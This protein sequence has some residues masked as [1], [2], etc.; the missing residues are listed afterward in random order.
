MQ[1]RGVVRHNIGI[2]PVQMMLR[3]HQVNGFLNTFCCIALMLML[4]ADFIADAAAVIGLPQ[5]ILEADGPYD[6]IRPV[7]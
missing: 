1:R 4:L 7:L 5:N 3:E 6:F 2:D